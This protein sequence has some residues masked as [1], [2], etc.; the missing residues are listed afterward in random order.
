MDESDL[1]FGAEKLFVWAL[2]F[3]GGILSILTGF[4]VGTYALPIFVVIVA[5]AL[6]ITWIAGARERWWLLVPA[7]GTLGGYFYFGYKIYPHEVALLACLVPLAMALA[8][9]APITQ[10]RTTAFPTTMYLLGFYLIVHWLGSTIYN[11]V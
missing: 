11:W 1:K 7:A 8:V 5:M 6:S 9:R 10:Q 2:I 3:L 4:M